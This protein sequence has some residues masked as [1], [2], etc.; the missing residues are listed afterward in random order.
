MGCLL[1]MGARP[2]TVT[3]QPEQQL[4]RPSLAGQL[5]VASPNI[6]D[7]RFFHTVILLLRHTKDGAFGIVINRPAA[8]VSLAKLLEG[9]GEKDKAA[10]GDVDL[11]AGG[12]VQPEAGFVI[13]SAEYSRTG[14]VPVN[15]LVAVT[16]SVE[17]FRDIGHRKGPSKSL[18][19][20]GYA[21]WGPNQLEFELSHDAWFTAMADPKL[22]FDE[23][24]DRLWD[25]AMERRLRAL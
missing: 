8:K 14:T 25:A 21:G 20:F 24:R 23:Q 6:G 5:L 1:L 12:P 19:A 2:A 7:P 13:H 15:G 22:I 16:S 10:D 3:P 9:L 18:I 17:V 11:Y 4:E